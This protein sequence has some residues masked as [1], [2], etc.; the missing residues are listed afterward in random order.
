[1]SRRICAVSVDLDE[2]D[3]YFDIHGLPRLSDDSPVRHLVYEVALERM[4][5][6]AAERGIALTLF[7]IGRDLKREANAEGLLALSKEGHVVENHSFNHRYDLTQF[8]A[9]VMAHEV[10]DGARIIEEVTGRRPVGFR[11]PGYTVNERLFDV[12][13]TLGVRFDSSVFPCPW[14]YAAKGAAMG[15]MRLGGRVSR[16]MMGSPWVLRA[17]MRPYRPGEVWFEEAERKTEGRSFVELPVQVTRGLRLPLIGTSL[18]LAGARG[19]RWL[20]R[21][22]VGEELVNLELH[23]IDFLDVKDGLGEL[24]THQPELRIPLE[25]RLEALGGALATLSE[26]GYSFV[27]L[28]EAARVFA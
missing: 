6:F 20:M 25:A 28:E 12:L 2:I 17:P 7:A 10:E 14:Y 1:M 13:D 8:D 9:S 21:G 23:G 26:E 16:A 18:A 22:C 19:A 15:A 4:R 24:A 3:N 5:A 27:R 11:A